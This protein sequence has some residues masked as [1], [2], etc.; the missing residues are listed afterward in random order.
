[1]GVSVSGENLC[2]ERVSVGGFVEDFGDGFA[3][4]VAGAGFV[5]E[6]DDGSGVG[7]GLESRAEL[8]GVGGDDAVVAVAGKDEDGRV[9][10]AGL[11]VVEG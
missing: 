4:A 7:V 9:E 5:S 6:E 2:Q 11:D 8:K 3:S 10:L 1:M